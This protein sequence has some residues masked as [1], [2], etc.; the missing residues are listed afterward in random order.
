MPFAGE[1]Q[2]DPAVLEAL[3]AE[4]RAYTGRAEQVDRALFQD[5]GLDPALDVLAAGVPSTTDSIPARCSRCDSTSPAGPAPTI[6]TEGIGITSS[7]TW[8]RPASQAPIAISA[9]ATSSAASEAFQLRVLSRSA[10]STI[11]PAAPIRYPADCT[12]PDNR[13]ATSAVRAAVDM[14]TQAS[15]RARRDRALHGWATASR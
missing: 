10:P 3:P 7:L 2:V 14:C 15:E 13:R 12:V 1:L 9:T 6:P 5:A 4:P 8:F 11:G